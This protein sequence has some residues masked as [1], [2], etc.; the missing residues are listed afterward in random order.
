[1]SF[2]R[3][4]FDKLA[5]K[6]WSELDFKPFET[7]RLTPLAPTIGAEIE[8][9]DLS[10]DVPEPQLVELRRALAERLVL[11]F[12]DQIIT[13]EEQKGFARHFGRLHRHELAQD[14][15]FAGRA[16]DPELLAWKTGPESR[17]T[18]GDAWHHDV[19]CDEEP[20]AASFLHVTKSPPYGAGDTAFAN[21]YLAYESLS[22]PI[23]RL[24]EGLTAIHD[25]AFGWQEGYGAQPKP[26]QTFP[27]SEHPVVVTHPV[28][29]RKI[30]FVNEA[31]TSRIVQLARP[32]SDA[33]LAFLYRH[34]ERN[35]AFQV[36][37]HWSVNALVVW[38]NWGAQHHAVWDYYPLERWGNR[39]SS[40]SGQ[41]PASSSLSKTAPE[42]SAAE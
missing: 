12:R 10:R 42:A 16:N 4:Y 23:K 37:V 33:L 15:T 25:G 26:G 9:V 30:L 20:I 3:D 13:L 36:R 29:G 21:C 22:D 8:G 7:F 31:F 24:L 2:Y 5:I 27:K 19:S 34:I 14:K 41:R 11:V 32:E 17:F 38:D 39:I 35:L 1:M 28:T 6:A 40:V 18:A